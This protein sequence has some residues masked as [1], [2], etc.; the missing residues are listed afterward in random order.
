MA[1]V[2]PLPSDRPPNPA[3]AAV[4]GTVVTDSPTP[5]RECSPADRFGVCQWFHFQDHD[6]V[7]RTVELLKEL[8]IRHLRTGISWADYLRPG[9]KDWYDWQMKTLRDFDVLLSVWHTPPSLSEGGSCN[10]PPKRLRD[11]ADFIDLV[12]TQYGDCFSQ[13]E[14]WNEPNN[15]LKWEFEKFDPQWRKFDEMIGSAAY[16]AKQRG[17]STV[18]GGIIPVDHHWLALMQDYGVMNYVDIVAIHAFPGMWW[19]GQPN[20]DWHE[21]WAGWDVKVSYIAEHAGHRPIW[22]TETGFSTWDLALRRESKYELQTAALKDALN[23]P[24][25]RVY[26]YSLI[27][28]DPTR[29]AI[30]G[31]HVDE[32]EY[33]MGLVKFDGYKKQAWHLLKNL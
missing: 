10:S 30:E 31:F 27:D 26:W 15:R 16:W 1:A 21:H 3:G 14:L 8:G 20:W 13:L 28:L 17:C 5:R 24:G 6:S 19:P 12:I 22:I 23:S 4:E 32:N 9:G 2:P 7:L 11:Y 18:L 29:D 25:G 33:H